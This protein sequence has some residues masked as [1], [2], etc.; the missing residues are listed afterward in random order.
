[1]GRPPLYRLVWFPG[2]KVQGWHDPLAFRNLGKLTTA[3]LPVRP[4]LDPALMLWGRDLDVWTQSQ[5]RPQSAEDAASCGLR[6]MHSGVPMGPKD[7]RGTIRQPPGWK[8]GHSW[9]LPPPTALPHRPPSRGT[10]KRGIQFRH[11]KRTEHVPTLHL[12]SDLMHIPGPQPGS[13]VKQAE[14]VLRKALLPAVPWSPCAQGR[15][16]LESKFLAPRDQLAM[17]TS[18]TLDRSLPLL[19]L[20]FI[21]EALSCPPCEG[22]E[23]PMRWWSGFR[24]QAVATKLCPSSP[25]PF[26][27]SSSLGP[28]ESAS[29]TRWAQEECWVDRCH[30]FGPKNNQNPYSVH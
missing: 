20:C 17:V 30:S 19:G 14:P 6:E 26:S 4:S 1:M 28:P 11:N 2:S 13:S 5:L 16:G 9:V 21:W 22:F 7:A 12:Q 29:Y 15:F 24:T 8:I 27:S 18:M 10:D 23:G 3:Q 25:W